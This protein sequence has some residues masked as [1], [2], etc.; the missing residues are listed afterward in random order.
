M[1][2]VMSAVVSSEQK[3]ALLMESMLEVSVPFILP[4]VGLGCWLV[5]ERERPQIGMMHW[6]KSWRWVCWSV[7]LSSN[8]VNFFLTSS[9][10]RSKKSEAKVADPTGWPRSQKQLVNSTGMSGAVL[11]VG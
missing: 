6:E 10:R 9:M 3:N 7:I 1:S 11:S 2:G 8:E 4:K 5:N